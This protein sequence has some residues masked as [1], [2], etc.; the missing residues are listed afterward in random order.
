MKIG[1]GTLAHANDNYGGARQAYALQEF[2]KGEGHEAF[3]CNTA[4]MSRRELRASLMKVFKSHPL[5]NLQEHRKT[6]AFQGFW[7]ECFEFDVTGHRDFDDYVR[8]PPPCDAL[9]C[10]SDQVWTPG[11]CHGDARTDFYFLNFVSPKTRRIA[12]AASLGS[13]TFPPDASTTLP[14]ILG[15]FDAIGVREAPAV[16]AVAAMGR[17]DAV[18]VCDPTLLHEVGFWGRL[19]DKSRARWEDNLLFC[20]EYRWP[21]AVDRDAVRRRLSRELGLQ[22]RV[23]F[24]FA[25]LH[26]WGSG[27]SP[28][29]YDWLNGIRNAKAVLTNSFHCVVFSVHFR[30]PF[31]LMRLQGRHAAMNERFS[32]LLKR[33]G[34]EAR[35]LDT[36]DEATVAERMRA[37]IDWDA[38]GERLASWREASSKFLRTALARA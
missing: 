4:P 22:A 14:G 19:A 35:M 28:T 18:E 17:P 11:N 9:I 12:Y 8:N 24:P 7:R 37:P 27:C 5:R 31:L 23:P 29:P 36:G 26:Y 3:L 32:S 20:Q 2:L 1:I 6:L 10:G 16:A 34:L 13:D 33:L 21:T 25:P 30:R 38:V 15:R